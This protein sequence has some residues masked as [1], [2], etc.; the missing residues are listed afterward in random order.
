MKP[1][2]NTKDIVEL[3]KRAAHTLPIF[4]SFMNSIMKSTAAMRG[5]GV[6]PLKNLYRSMEK[7][8]FRPDGN[9]QW[10][11]DC[12]L[13]VVRG[14]LIFDNMA[15]MLASF[16]KIQSHQGVVIHRCKDRFTTP[17][18]GGWRDCMVNISF[19]SD[20]NHFICELQLIHSKLM[21]ARQGMA[22]HND[23]NTYRSAGELRDA[24][25][26]RRSKQTAG[27][28]RRVTPGPKTKHGATAATSTHTNAKLPTSQVALHGGHQS[29][30]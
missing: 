14:A 25:M 4:T 7:C 2:Q 18:A 29:H 1:R 27:H 10:D 16:R 17:T 28:G 15:S 5:S 6:G 12:V 8:A 3:Y 24:V 30:I 19:V 20:P 23:Y 9:N 22:G 26:Y 21:L 11:A 13:D